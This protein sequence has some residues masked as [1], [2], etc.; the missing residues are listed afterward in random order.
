MDISEI[1]SEGINPSLNSLTRHNTIDSKSS[2]TTEIRRVD[3]SK[4]N[5]MFNHMTTL[6]D[7]SHNKKFIASWIK[8]GKWTIE[9]HEFDSN[10]EK[11]KRIWSFELED[12][13]QSSLNKESHYYSFISVSSKGDVVISFAPIGLNGIKTKSVDSH[14]YMINNKSKGTEI[15]KKG[16][17]SGR[18]VF[19]E[20]DRLALVNLEKLVVLNSSYQFDYLLDIQKISVEWLKSPK[21]IIKNYMWCEETREEGGAGMDRAEDL[22]AITRHINQGILITAYKNDVIRLWRVDDG[23]LIMSIKTK[24]MMEFMAISKYYRLIATYHDSKPKAGES[25]IGEFKISIYD[26]KSGLVVNELCSKNMNRSPDFEVISLIFSDN[27]KNLLMVGVEKYGGEGEGGYQLVSECWDIASEKTISYREYPPFPGSKDRKG[28]L[29]F[30][31]ERKSQGDIEVVIGKPGYGTSA[32]DHQKT[33]RREKDRSYKFIYIN[34]TKNLGGFEN[35]WICSNKLDTNKL[36]NKQSSWT[37]L[38]HSIDFIEQENRSDAVAGGVNEQ[39]DTHLFSY[40]QLFTPLMYNHEIGR[41]YPNYPNRVEIDTHINYMVI[42]R[43]GRYTVQIWRKNEDLADE[44]YE[45]V[46]IRAYKPPYYD[47]DQNFED[48]L[49]LRKESEPRFIAKCYG[50][51]QLVLYHYLSRIGDTTVFLDEIFLPINRIHSGAGEDNYCMIESACSALQYLYEKCVTKESLYKS[52]PTDMPNIPK[53]YVT[54]ERLVKEEVQNIIQYESRYFSTISGSNTMALLASFPV[55]QAIL[56]DIFM[57]SKIPINIFSYEGKIPDSK[58]KKH[59]YRGLKENVLTVL[60]NQDNFN[61]ANFIFIKNIRD[62]K[63]LGPGQFT[64]LMDTLLYLQS[65]ENVEL[66]LTFTKRLSYIRT[67]RHSYPT[68][69]QETNEYNI[70]E[71]ADSTLYTLESYCSLETLPKYN[72]YT[73]F[74]Y[75]YDLEDKW[76]FMITTLENC[77]KSLKILKVNYEPKSPCKLCII[78]LPYFNSY[79]YHDDQ[80]STQSENNMTVNW[81]MKNACRRDKHSLEPGHHTKPRKRKMNK[82]YNKYKSRSQFVD[83]SSSEYKNQIFKQGGTVIEVLLSYKWKEFGF[84]TFMIM[85]MIHLMYYSSFIAAVSFPKEL[86]GYEPGTTITHPQHLAATVLLFVSFGII[87]IQELRQFMMF[88]KKEYFAS[89]YN[90]ID[91]AS[92]S[93]TITSFVQLLYNKELRLEVGSIT[94]LMLWMHAMLR[95]RIIKG[96]GVALEIIIQLFRK[97]LPILLIMFL[98]IL[99]FTHSMVYLLLGRTDDFFQDKFEAES[100]GLT[101]EA[102]STSSSNQFGNPFRA[103]SILWF[104]LFGVWDPVV[105]GD[106]GDDTMTIILSIL[107]SFITVIIFLNIVIAIMSNTVENMT[108]KGNSIWLSHFAAVLAEMEMVWCFMFQRHNRR[109]NPNFIYYFGSTKEIAGQEESL[110][111]E[112]DLVQSLLVKK[113][114]NK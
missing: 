68:L 62:S 63:L 44:D 26:G 76:R 104:L 12:N 13:I 95:L 100:D 106:V 17:F 111:N 27:E 113:A 72:R 81:L 48:N 39:C 19:L 83:N 30:I 35:Y 40:Y 105:E 77:Y 36:E 8:H 38:Q 52:N 67:Y 53:L 89:F 96:F 55:G 103:F 114:Q 86:Y 9:L 47:S 110:E 24:P 73:Q 20:D 91:L 107:F 102:H 71:I 6:M 80:E 1:L 42:L 70:T 97:I 79:L 98:V 87:L 2:Q 85:M 22:I 90:Y 58:K 64:A 54:T 82:Y 4:E 46:F 94:I 31:V 78:P 5:D 51:I 14:Y 88:S 29:P 37:L 7:I 25:K 21:E 66:L 112:A 11:I 41:P 92:Y 34:K 15:K 23:S 33:Y 69:D 61:L 74:I 49:E 18:A 59:N 65:R 3:D 56:Q 16:R 108:A 57:H 99:A 93:L 101:I 50:R 109:N 84:R 32:E 28:I 60:I 43:F 75:S 10:F 45:L